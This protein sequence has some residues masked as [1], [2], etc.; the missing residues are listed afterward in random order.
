MDE[1]YLKNPASELDYTVD[2]NVR[3]LAAGEQIS[4]DLG[5]SVTP[6][7]AAAGGLAVVSASSTETTTT[8]ILGGGRPGDA[9]A[10]SSRIQTTD[11]REI[12]KSLTIRVGNS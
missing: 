5:W 3:F 4:S 8:A 12:R 7:D 6:D 1:Y 10:V 9:Y 2:W 11:G